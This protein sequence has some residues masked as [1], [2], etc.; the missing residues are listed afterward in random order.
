MEHVKNVPPTNVQ[1]RNV[2]AANVTPSDASTNSD[3]NNDTDAPPA[4][5]SH[6]PMLQSPVAKRM[7]RGLQPHLIDPMEN[8]DPVET[9]VTQELENVRVTRS[10]KGNTDL[11]DAHAIM[12]CL[13]MCDEFEDF[14]EFAFMAVEKYDLKASLTQAQFSSLPQEISAVL[15]TTDGRTAPPGRA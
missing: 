7:V 14:S 9:A 15:R 10:R 6:A 11:G 3:H 12:A 2:L 1:P 8:Q 4:L 5:F 13:A